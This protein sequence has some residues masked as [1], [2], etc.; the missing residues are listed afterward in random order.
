LFT[1]GHFTST[2]GTSSGIASTTR[3][4]DTANTPNDATAMGTLDLLGGNYNPRLTFAL[5]N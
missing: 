1:V 4:I 2:G 5:L 3:G